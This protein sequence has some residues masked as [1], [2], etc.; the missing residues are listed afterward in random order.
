[1]DS[2]KHTAITFSGTVTSAASSIKSPVQVL[3]SNKMP[4]PTGV[5][6]EASEYVSKSREAGQFSGAFTQIPARSCSPGVTAIRSD[7]K[8]PPVFPSGVIWAPL[9]VI[10]AATSQL[11]PVSVQLSKPI[12]VLSFWL[13]PAARETAGKNC[14][15]ITSVSRRLTVRRITPFAMFF[16]VLPPLMT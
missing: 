16:I 10:P 7:C 9:P 4:S 12:N 6:P 2:C 1:M 3:V 8:T 11:P 15:S 13:S 5:L 14:R